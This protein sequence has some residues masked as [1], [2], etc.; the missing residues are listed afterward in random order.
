[1][2]NACAANTI[3]VVIEKFEENITKKNESYLINLIWNYLSPGTS[4][5]SSGNGTGN[6][7]NQNKK[8]GDS[9][10][11]AKDENKYDAITVNRNLRRRTAGSRSYGYDQV[12]QELD[13]QYEKITAAQLQITSDK[14]GIAPGGW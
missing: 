13:Q 12:E 14:S 1:M 4:G 10:G 11:C 9:N 6:D 2:L 8:D 5:S 7:D 3:A